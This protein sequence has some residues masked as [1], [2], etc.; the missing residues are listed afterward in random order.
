MFLPPHSSQ[1][2]AGSGKPKERPRFI[3]NPKLKLRE[4]VHEVIRF[5]HY[6]ART[7]E[8]YWHWIRRFLVF[9]RQEAP[10]PH[11]GAGALPV[12]GPPSPPTPLPRER[13]ASWRH[14]RDLGAEEVAAFLGHLATE[15]NVAAATQNQALNALIFLYAE[16]LG[17][18]LGELDGFARA[19]RPA[20]LPS[21]LNAAEVARLLEAV[22]LDYRLPVQLLYGSGLRL[23]ELLRLRIKD[24]DLERRQILVRDGKGFKDRVTMVPESLRAALR[25]QLA[26]A[27]AVWQGD[28]KAGLPGVWLPDALAR[29]FPKAPHEW[30]WFWLFPARKPARDPAS[31]QVRRHHQLEDNLQRAV[32]AAAL[33]ARIHKRVSTHTLRHSFA[34]H[35][36]ES[37]TDIRTVQELLGHASVE[38][39][40]IYTHV[41][42]KPGL[43]VRSP[44]D[45]G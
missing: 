3:P 5:F 29:K 30:A 11:P 35:L 6:S 16:V 25:E 13:G 36:L 7:E 39:T 44:L 34:T 45:A 22:A 26:R 9:H 43:G 32:K 17:Q 38:T 15:R 24:V 40:Q 33:K 20:R 10:A 21:V 41:M 37:G 28:R 18:P 8:V 23:I 2:A 4:Q 31:G 19:R 14:P 42:S 27:R 12:S 1:S